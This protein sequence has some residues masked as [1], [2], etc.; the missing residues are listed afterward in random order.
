MTKLK[1]LAAVQ[2]KIRRLH[3]D[4]IIAE[5][6]KGRFIMASSIHFCMLTL[7]ARIGFFQRVVPGSGKKQ[8]NSYF[9]RRGK[10]QSLSMIS[11][12]FCV[13]FS[14]IHVNGVIPITIWIPVHNV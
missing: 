14:K 2:D 1:M 13:Q 3:E 6:T 9:Q 5:L 7:I 4:K 12:S 11:F 8:V 10:S